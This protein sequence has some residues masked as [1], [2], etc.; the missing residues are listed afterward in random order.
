MPQETVA[1]RNI[2]TEQLQDMLADPRPEGMTEAHVIQQLLDWGV[3]LPTVRDTRLD[4]IEKKAQVLKDQG[5]S[6]MEIKDE[7]SKDP[8]FQTDF[9]ELA[10][11]NNAKYV[12]KEWG[13]VLSESRQ[14]FGSSWGDLALAVV[15]PSTYKGLWGLG[16]EVGQLATGV[17]PGTP[18]YEGELIPE[19][20][21]PKWRR[22]TDRTRSDSP[23]PTDYPILQSIASELL[24]Y[25]QPG[26]FKRKVATD[27]A[28]VFSDAISLAVPV[29]GTTAKV[30]P[31]LATGLNRSSA[32]LQLVDPPSTLPSVAAGVTRR[33]TGQSM[34]DSLAPLPKQ[35]TGPVD[36]S[37]LRQDV[38]QAEQRQMGQDGHLSEKLPASYISELEPAVTTDSWWYQEGNQKI[39][40]PLKAVENM[41]QSIVEDALDKFGGRVDAN[42]ATQNLLDSFSEYEKTFRQTEGIMFDHLDEMTGGLHTVPADYSNTM[43]LLQKLE[44]Y[45]KNATAAIGEEAGNIKA[46]KQTLGDIVKD[47]DAEAVPTPTTPTGGEVWQMTR[48]QLSSTPLYHASFGPFEGQ[49]RTGRLGLFLAA[50]PEA[51]TKGGQAGQTLPLMGIS[52]GRPDTVSAFTIDPGAKIFGKDVVI[53]NIDLP[54]KMT[55][56]EFKNKIG[57]IDTTTFAE[58]S[59]VNQKA[60]EIAKNTLNKFYIESDIP[61]E[62]QREILVRSSQPME[63]RGD[64][65]VP[66]DISSDP[67]FAPDWEGFEFEGRIPEALRSLG[68]DA[69]FVRDEAGVSLSVLNDQALRQTTTPATPTSTAPTDGVSLQELRE[70]RQRIRDA[71][72]IAQGGDST[73][74]S[75]ASYLEQTESSLSADIAKSVDAHPDEAFRNAYWDRMEQ[76]KIGQERIHSSYGAVIRDAIKNQGAASVMDRLFFSG[77]KGARPKL[78]N[79]QI[80]D[81]F[82]AV[83]THTADEIRSAFLQEIIRRSQTATGNLTATGLTTQ[84][85]RLAQSGSY[86]DGV[87]RFAAIVDDQGVTQNFIDLE[88]ILRGSE[89]FQRK[90]KTGSKTAFLMKG[91]APNRF[92]DKLM[93]QP[94]FLGQ[95]GGAIFKG[96]VKAG[97]DTLVQSLATMALLFGVDHYRTFIHPRV[98]Y[99]EGF[100]PTVDQVIQLVEQLRPAQSIVTKT[101]MQSRSAIEQLT[102]ERRDV[103]SAIMSPLNPISTNVE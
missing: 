32:I 20:D 96:T 75:T 95:L 76:N 89:P 40:G 53:G 77:G 78:T 92:V 21:R 39:L 86:A 55:Y 56:S 84:M 68:Y 59:R 43:A 33:M 100:G 82:D 87:Q 60:K 30:L 88:T 3:T 29:L 17:K 41:R 47:V 66:I 12:G 19:R 91:D 62:R 16:K 57:E 9:F 101:G 93:S 83:G 81:I 48:S 35:P 46:L 99:V 45:D 54:E 28:G 14:N 37:T 36:R 1:K 23:M 51:A 18:R 102:A 67:N 58:D 34:L 97:T 7:I 15:N 98:R 10:K 69:G 63:V 8:E 103:G 24:S 80:G 2:S 4:R 49:P 94:A 64:N 27:P 61:A 73:A 25:V 50:T 65:V 74:R 70:V 42:T 38:L 11:D 44:G 31:K 5:R 6:I 52:Q 90:A 85:G 22:P 79:K 71:K 13:D 26:G 72:I